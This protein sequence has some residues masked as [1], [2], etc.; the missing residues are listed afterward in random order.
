MSAL[1]NHSIS[2]SDIL[3]YV[4]SVK[5]PHDKWNGYAW[6]NKFLRRNNKILKNKPLKIIAQGRV[7]ETSM[8][9][10]EEFIAAVNMK[11]ETFNMTEDNI[12]NVDEFQLKMTGY[13]A[14]RRRITAVRPSGKI[15]KQIATGV[16]G[17]CV[18]SLISFICNDG[19]LYFCAL[20]LKP[21]GKIR[22]KSSPTEK[23]YIESDNIEEGKNTRKRPAPQLRIYTESGMIDN[24]CWDIIF[25]EFLK[26]HNN[27]TPGKPYLVYMDNLAQHT[28][29]RCIEKGLKHNVDSM[30]LVK[31]TSQYAQPC[32]S[33]PFGSMRMEI[34]KECSNKMGKNLSGESLNVLIRDLVPNAMA[35]SFTPVKI[36]AAFKVTGLYPFNEEVIRRNCQENLGSVTDSE[37]NTLS[38]V[39]E[40]VMNALKNMYRKEDSKSSGKKRVRATIGLN[41]AYS[42]GHVIKMH[43]EQVRRKD[44]ESTAKIMRTEA[45]EE[46]KK[47]IQRQKD[48]KKL[49]LVNKRSEASAKKAEKMREIRAKVCT[50][51]GRRKTVKT[52]DV[53]DWFRCQKCL[54]Y[55]VCPNHEEEKKMH[56]ETC[57]K[58]V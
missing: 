3:H 26:H 5:K 45:A 25:T 22:N 9:S 23:Y 32:D 35:K 44:E 16:R 33:Y 53:A 15:H 56:L 47:E 27:T 12:L 10:I 14:G 6:L 21:D 54:D 13:A 11:A 8:E 17:G 4:E 34:N 41:Q 37:N 48:E 46:K 19:S 49:A 29:L 28:Q 36:K 43:E 38:T 58:V 52:K 24:E 42:A 50:T 55:T 31:G 30:F 18:G 40:N 51:C 1:T 39:E 57:Q 7:D 20:C 2:K